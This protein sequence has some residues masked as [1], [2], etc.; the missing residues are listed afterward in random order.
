MEK[1]GSEQRLGGGKEVRGAGTGVPVF[2]ALR[3][4]GADSLRLAGAPFALRT[5][6]ES[7]WLGRRKR[8]SRR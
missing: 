2:W 8:E 5:A 1:A 3:S 6:T 7:V 4:T